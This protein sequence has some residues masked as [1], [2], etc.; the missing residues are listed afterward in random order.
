MGEESRGEV[1]DDRPLPRAAPLPRAPKG[2]GGA[3]GRE[4]EIGEERRGE[5][6]DDTWGPQVSERGGSHVSKYHPQNSCELL[7]GVVCPIL[8]G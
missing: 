1:D 7:Q 4:R 5:V 2:G 8:R 6:D 3:A